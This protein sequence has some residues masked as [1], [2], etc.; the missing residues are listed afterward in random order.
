MELSAPG[1]EVYSTNLTNTYGYK[2]GTSM[3]CPHVSGVAAL[4]WSYQCGPLLS[5][6]G[7][8]R[9]LQLN[10]HD[11]GA[12]GRDKYYGFGRTV[13]FTT[14][15]D[16]GDIFYVQ[17]FQKTPVTWQNTEE[18]GI[19]L[20]PETERTWQVKDAS[21]GQTI[22][23]NLRRFYYDFAIRTS[24]TI[25]FVD[26]AGSVLDTFNISDA[27]YSFERA[28]AKDL[29]DPPTSVFYLAMFD[30]SSSDMWDNRRQSGVLS[31]S[32]LI[33]DAVERLSEDVL[34][35]N[36][37]VPFLDKTLKQVI[38]DASA[39][40]ISKEFSVSIGCWSG[41]LFTDNDRNGYPDWW[42][43][44]RR[45]EESPYDVGT[46]RYVGTGPYRVTEFDPT[47]EKV[48]LER[49]QDYW[50]GWPATNRIS[51]LDKIELDYI[52]D[53]VNRR[54]AFK[55]GQLDFC[56]VPRAY[57]YDLLDT[58]G[59]PR[60]FTWPEGP[61]VPGN[62]SIKTIKNIKPVLGCDAVFF[63]FNVDPISPFVPEVNG[64]ANP[65]LFNGVNMRKAFAYAF[66]HTEYLTD[67][68]YDEAVCQET[69]QVH[70]LVPDYYTKATDPPWTYDINY[71]AAKTELTTAGVWTSGFEVY[72]VYQ[73]GDEMSR[74]ACEMIKRFFDNFPG[75]H[76][77]FSSYILNVDPSILPTY[78]KDNYLPI[79]VMSWQARFADTDD[80]MRAFMHSQGHCAKYQGYTSSGG[81]TA[82][83]SRTGL[84]KDELIDLAAKTQ[85][86][87]QRA[88][89]Y[90]DL[91]DIYLSD[92]PSFPIAQRTGRVWMK[93]WVKGWYYN[94][95]YP[96]PYYYKMYKQMASW[97]DV[98]SH[99]IGVPDGVVDM[100]DIGYIAS[101]FVS[102]APDPYNEPPYKY[103]LWAPGAYGCGGC[104]VYGDRVVDM[105][106][107][108]FAAS[109]FGYTILP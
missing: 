63:T 20:E 56:D 72:V 106:D 87:P 6:S 66:N 21:Y 28:L 92:V 60:N 53:W 8:R 101:A 65:N 95:L 100:R 67:A 45:Q 1:V 55:R 105:R 84:T 35:I 13:A 43:T 102:W 61:D 37:G 4:A 76:G 107:I 34:R 32:F 40:I 83:G 89:Y 86:G 51:Y 42:V 12:P 77:T 19:V 36:V 22:I 57:M 49:N 39:S 108:G 3:A 109:H 25:S 94:A 98:I 64:V 11:L 52:P 69:P 30:Q 70:G 44:I 7:L 47:N 82:T 33:E 29:S 31:L 5:N 103:P 62:A 78:F 15:P 10:V 48:V 81:W 96:S 14:V 74:I 2:S 91:D 50:R 18:D 17:E 38:C 79:C 90:A 80:P 41:S 58:Y 75:T 16:E 88:Q 93:Y 27:E 68:Y 97:S 99:T 59:Q 24:P 26:E 54:E 46:H 23:F 73:T 85:D 9:L 71:T 104:D